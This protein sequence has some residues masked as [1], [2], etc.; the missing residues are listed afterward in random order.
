M[1]MALGWA[2]LAMAV[3]AGG[4]QPVSIQYHGDNGSLPPPYRRSTSI[5]VDAQGRG[6]LIRRHGYDLTDP[7]Q[8]FEA[9]FV[10]SVDQREAFA[11]RLDE[12]G[13]WKVR[14]KEQ[15]RP[16][17]GGS[18]VH[19]RLSSGERVIEVPAFPVASQREL[20]AQLRDA[21]TS[22]VPESVGA[23]RQAWEQGKGEA[24]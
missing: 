12:L 4:L 19:L 8:A 6:K 18:V 9:D 15:P 24:E 7:A 5:S 21:V 2:L 14:W 17:V 16:P 20:A 1:S 13:A 10:I 22:L 23:A 3:P 11:R